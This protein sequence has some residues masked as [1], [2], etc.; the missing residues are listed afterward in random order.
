MNN[1]RVVLVGP[2]RLLQDILERVFNKSYRLKIVSVIDSLDE[3]PAAVES[4][5]PHWVLLF[6]SF[7]ENIEE[8][9]KTLLSG[10]PDLQVLTIA[11]DGSH[12][13]MHWVEY[14]TESLERIN[15]DELRSILEND[16]PVQ[17]IRDR[18][19]SGLSFGVIG[20]PPGFLEP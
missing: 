8:R 6:L 11:Q 12:L 9:V 17:S 20:S 10:H 3:L 4:T 7:G 19:G 2:P 1:R 15:L 13:S 5:H 18:K 16:F 14:Q